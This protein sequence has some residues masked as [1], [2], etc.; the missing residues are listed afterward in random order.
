MTS[1]TP[2]TPKRGISITRIVVGLIIVG[3]ALWFVF[4]NTGTVTVQLWVA[5]MSMPMWITLLVTFA[6]GWLTG[7]LLRGLRKK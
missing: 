5:S 6:A 3:L 1:T 4:A 7:L 2:D